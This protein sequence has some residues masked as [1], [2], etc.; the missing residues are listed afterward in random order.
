MRRDR[1]EAAVTAGGK[2]VT[3]LSE[4]LAPARRGVCATDWLVWTV[5]GTARTRRR[6]PGFRDE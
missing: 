3:L 4:A 5:S 6:T 1:I 2:H